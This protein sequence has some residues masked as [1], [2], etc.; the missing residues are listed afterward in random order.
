[1]AGTTDEWSQ[2]K[3]KK[4]K[5]KIQGTLGPKVNILLMCTVIAQVDVFIRRIM[6][7]KLTQCSATKYS[8]V[9]TMLLKP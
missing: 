8:P 4:R 2:R 7:I 6:I 1:M 9:I 3:E 5:R